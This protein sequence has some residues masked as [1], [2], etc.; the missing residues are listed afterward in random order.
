M[1]TLLVPV[2]VISSGLLVG[3]RSLD[4]LE[5]GPCLEEAI[6]GEAMTCS[7]GGT[8]REYD[9]VLPADYNPET[10]TGLVIVLHG[11]GGNK[12][13]ALRTTCP[14]GDIDDPE[15]LHAVATEHSLAVVAPNGTDGFLDA[16][17]WNAGGGGDGFRCVGGN[18]CDENTDDIA[19]T[20]A[21]IDDIAT[22]M[23]LDPG[24]VY[25]TGISNG[26]AMAHR[27]ACELP[28]R[29]TAIA[30][31]GGANQFTT[32]ATCDPAITIP[33]LQVHGTEDPCWRYEGGEPN[34]P[35]GERDKK[36]VSVARTMS[37]WSALKRC[38]RTPLEDQLPDTESD[39]TTTLRR[40]WQECATELTLLKI[41][42]GGHTWPRGFQYLG[43]NTIGPVPQDWG[44]EVI[45]NFFLKHRR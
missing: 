41:E 4:S 34:C 11:G 44:N 37:E 3:C 1:K 16:R 13:A 18:A 21:L 2:L 26:G 30:A 8:E 23:N 43:T 33:I 40:T 36:F 10:P 12:S 27:L 6:A 29:I 22:R 28:E 15:C 5:T 45:V 7:V 39:G 17:S 19:F 32:N 25:V 14:W 31:V 9:L 24:R 42:G 20:E 35:V 38:S